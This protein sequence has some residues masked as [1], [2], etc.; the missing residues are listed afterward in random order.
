MVGNRG[1]HRRKYGYSL[2]KILTIAASHHSSS[3]ADARC[4]G[5]K[6]RDQGKVSRRRGRVVAGWRAG[7]K[8]SIAGRYRGVSGGLKKGQCRNAGAH[9]LGGMRSRFG[10]QRPHWR[11]R[12]RGISCTSKLAY[13]RGIVSVERQLCLSRCS[14]DLCHIGDVIS[15]R[16]QMRTT[17][18]ATGDTVRVGCHRSDE[19]SGAPWGNA[20]SGAPAVY[21]DRRRGAVV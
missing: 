10:S 13:E 17:A 7:S 15:R 2:L 12:T 9:A 3:A 8:G 14:A 11:S 5:P 1:V 19:P 21:G 16:T 4:M 20:T 18:H 6:S